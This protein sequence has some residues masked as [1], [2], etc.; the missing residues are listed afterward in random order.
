MPNAK[1][2]LKCRWKRKE[3]GNI[4]KLS[5]H[6]NRQLKELEIQMLNQYMKLYK[7][8]FKFKGSVFYR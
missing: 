2:V 8:S 7:Y 1:M 5:Q 6:N 3:L 4:K